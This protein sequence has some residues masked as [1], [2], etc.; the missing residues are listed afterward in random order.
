M[1]PFE[2][3]F[4][5]IQADPESFV[6]IVFSSLVSEFLLLPKGEGFVDYAIFERGYEHLKQ[7]SEAFQA[8]TPARI[9]PVTIQQ[10][11]TIIVLR[12]ML[13]F[14][15]PEW[16]YV[17]TQRTGIEVSQGFTR[18]LDRKVRMRPTAPLKE[19][20]LTYERLKALVHVACQLLNKGAPKTATN[21]LHR[22]D[23]ADTKGGAESLCMLTSIGVPYAMLLLRAFSRTPLCRPPGFRQRASR[24]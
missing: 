10:P 3:T 11:I 17:T 4:E 12:A 24:R 21:R 15:P 14:T 7:A 5:Q 6:T 18:S 20:G 2:S 16:A 1:H 13:G 22:L 23:K 19:D 8:I 9:L